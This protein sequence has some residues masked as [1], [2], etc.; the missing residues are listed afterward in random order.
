MSAAKPWPWT[1]AY[2][3]LSRAERRR[4]NP[5][6]SIRCS[7]SGSRRRAVPPSKA[8]SFQF[9][10]AAR[11]MQLPPAIHLPPQTWTRGRRNSRTS[12]AA[13]SS[14]SEG[15]LGEVHPVAG[16]AR[17]HSSFGIAEQRRR[18]PKSRNRRCVSMRPFCLW[19]VAT[20][21]ILL[22]SRLPLG[23]AMAASGASIVRP[24]LNPQPQPRYAA[25]SR[26]LACQLHPTGPTQGDPKSS[27]PLV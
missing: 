16:V 5:M 26:R 1:V 24:R 10:K 20:H 2:R 19:K 17:G 6:Y 22:D 18:F 23:S 11:R 7:T 4:G 25:L 9:R 8:I 21:L 14:G 3:S 27:S 15:R 13:P 12:R